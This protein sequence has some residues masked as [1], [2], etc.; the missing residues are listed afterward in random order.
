MSTLSEQPAT[1]SGCW[2]CSKWY[3]ITEAQCPHCCAT[4]PNVDLESAQQECGSPGMIDHDWQFQDDSFGHEFGTEQ[5][6]YW[7]CGRCG[8]E[9]EM[10]PGDYHDYDD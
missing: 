8:K 4:N 1:E 7:R 2:N 5:I 6:H 9:R 10:Q 3:P